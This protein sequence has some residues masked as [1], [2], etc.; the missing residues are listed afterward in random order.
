MN[1]ASVA[2]KINVYGDHLP[3]VADDMRFGPITNPSPSICYA[4]A[5]GIQRSFGKLGNRG[6]ARLQAGLEAG[7]ET[8]GRT[9]RCK[10]ENVSR[11]GCRLQLAEPPRAGATA[12]V[13]FA[14]VEIM[15]TVSWVKAERCGVKFGRPLTLEQVE[16][17][18]WITEHASEHAIDSLA[19]A[20]EVWR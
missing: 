17:I 16:R 12:L 13:R 8:P 7:L 11:L 1:G 20:S 15:G 9:T 6:M 4:Q 5:M 18:R 14:E 3:R 19:S 10:V 2:T